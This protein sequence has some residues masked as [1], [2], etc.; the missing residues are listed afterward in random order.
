[1]PEFNSGCRIAKLFS[2]HIKPE[3]QAA[4]LSAGPVCV[5]VGT[6][7]RVDKLAAMSGALS[8][9]RCRLLVLDVSRDVKQ[10]CLLDLP[11]TRRDLWAL[12][13]THLAERVAAGHMRVALL[14]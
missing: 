7:A 1:M 8:L 2:K 6:P 9:S 12:W 3:E 14:S 11:E 10:R 13:R 5:A 4:Q